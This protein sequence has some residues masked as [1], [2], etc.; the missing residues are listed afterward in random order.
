MT[1][2]NLPVLRTAGYSQGSTGQNL[3]N[4]MDGTGA[5][6]NNRAIMYST[7]GYNEPRN[8]QDAMGFTMPLT[9]DPDSTRKSVSFEI[10]D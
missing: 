5:M 2:H 1:D 3:V 4:T 6:P 8:G 9:Y 10:K 7:Y